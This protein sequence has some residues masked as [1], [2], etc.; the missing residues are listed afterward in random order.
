M[1]HRSLISSTEILVIPRRRTAPSLFFRVFRVFRCV[2]FC[3]PFS[4]FP[5][6]ISPRSPRACIPFAPLAPLALMPS[7]RHFSIPWKNIFHTVEKSR[8]VFHTVENV[9]PPFLILHS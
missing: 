1:Y 3:F 6:A 8:M 7:A 2:R 4:G 5:I 9:Q